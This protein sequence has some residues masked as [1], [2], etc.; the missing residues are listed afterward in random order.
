M[1]NYQM[2][3]KETSILELINLLKTV[4]PTLKKEGKIVMVVDSFGSKKS[5][6]NKKKRKITKQKGGLAKKKAKE[7][8]SKGTCFHCGKEGHCKRNCKA[9]MESKKKVAY[10]LPSSSGTYVIEVNTVSHD[11]L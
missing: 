1:L 11:N 3:N 2:N 9:Y 10:D 4:E 7:T 8:S 5:S 6:K